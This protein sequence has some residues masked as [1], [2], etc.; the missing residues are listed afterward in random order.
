M[1]KNKNRQRLGVDPIGSSGRYSQDLLG[2]K[3]HLAGSSEFLATHFQQT[4]PKVPEVGVRGR[5]SQ[6]TLPLDSVF[7]GIYFLIFRNVF[8]G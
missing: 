4:L 2:L 3:T 6:G 5:L 8:R 1:F 7:R